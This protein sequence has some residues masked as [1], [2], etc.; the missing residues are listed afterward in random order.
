MD[1]SI[2]QKKTHK[3][4]DIL[5]ILAGQK[6]LNAKH[7]VGP[8]LSSTW[9]HRQYSLILFPYTNHHDMIA[10]KYCFYITSHI[11]TILILHSKY[12][13]WQSDSIMFTV[14]FVFFFLFSPRCVFC[15]P[16]ENSPLLTVHHQN[17][18]C[19]PHAVGK[20]S[21]LWTLP[22]ENEAEIRR[23]GEVGHR[24]CNVAIHSADRQACHPPPAS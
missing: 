6:F 22:G 15:H 24:I 11:H 8:D 19:V 5:T 21:L 10:Q 9:P 4:T 17:K 3:Y 14:G 23:G 2:W 1:K 16:V 18:P 7:L 20:C 12:V 13:T